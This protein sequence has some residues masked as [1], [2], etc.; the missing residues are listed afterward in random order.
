ML[1]MLTRG[2]VF[3]LTFLAI[4]IMYQVVLAAAAEACHSLKM[5]RWEKRGDICG[6]FGGILSSC[7]DAVLDST[8][9]GCN[10]CSKSVHCCSR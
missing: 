7:F 1:G 9:A 6:A 8:A 10:P 4:S 5:S 2:Q 3:L